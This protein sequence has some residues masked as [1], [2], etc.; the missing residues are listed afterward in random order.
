MIRGGKEIRT[1]IVQ[2]RGPRE[3]LQSKINHAE[4]QNGVLAVGTGIADEYIQ[5]FVVGSE[6]RRS[7]QRGEGILR[8]S[9][10]NVSLRQ[11]IF[12]I[13]RGFALTAQLRE[14]LN[15]A[16]EFAR[17]DVTKSEIEVGHEFVLNVAVC[18]QEM[19]NGFGKMAT[20]RQVH[21][22]SKLG[23]RLRVSGTAVGFH[24]GRSCALLDLSLQQKA[25]RKPDERQAPRDQATRQKRALVFHC[26]PTSTSL[27]PLPRAFHNRNIAID[28]KVCEALGFADGMA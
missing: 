14:C 2:S 13:G 21:A 8:L 3:V 23:F 17:A 27:L 15:R 25:G 22:S 18:R 4:A 5:F 6:L 20:P 11:E 19:R 24:L 12:H 9:I 16:R 26:L 28:G 10:P 1:L 7:L